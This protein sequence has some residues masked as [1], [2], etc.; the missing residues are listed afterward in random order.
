LRWPG[1]A[2]LQSITDQQRSD[3][4]TDFDIDFDFDTDTDSVSAPDVL[5]AGL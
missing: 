5:I 3:F 1:T 4:D 2:T